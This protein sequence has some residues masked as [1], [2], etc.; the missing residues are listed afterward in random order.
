MLY[1]HQ[2]V[3][4]QFIVMDYNR[5]SIPLNASDVI[6]PIF[7]EKNDMVKV[8]GDENDAVWLAHVHDVDQHSKTCRVHFY[9]QHATDTNVYRK[10]HS[11]IETVHWDSIV[12]LSSGR[13][14]RPGY[15][16]ADS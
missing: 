1:P 12:G 2:M 6:V 9:V 8:R 13:W 10:E 7:P 5:E 14:L 11:R 3:P 4:D 16:H 15:C